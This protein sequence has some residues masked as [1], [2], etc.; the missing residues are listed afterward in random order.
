MQNSEEKN[1]PVLVEEYQSSGMR[2]KD[3]AAARDLCPKKFRG[4]VISAKRRGSRTK[5][6][7]IFRRIVVKENKNIGGGVEFCFPGTRVRVGFEESF[8]WLSR[9]LKRSRDGV[10]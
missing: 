9:Y 5:E 4:Q 1:W 2:F 3:F 7:K 10:M 8:E 6:E